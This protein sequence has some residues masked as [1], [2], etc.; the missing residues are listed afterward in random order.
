MRLAWR[1]RSNLGLAVVAQSLLDSHHLEFGTNLK[2]VR[3]VTEDENRDDA[4][5]DQDALVP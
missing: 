2:V 5:L 3:I 4:G 1:P